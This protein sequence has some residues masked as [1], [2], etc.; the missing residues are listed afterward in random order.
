MKPL[1]L[2]PAWLRQRP[3]LWRVLLLSS[4]LGLAV[5]AVS[6]AS[7]NRLIVAPP[8]IPGATYAGSKSCEDCHEPITRRFATADH[9]RLSAVGKN[10]LDIGCESCH[11]PGSL[12]VESGGELR[13]IIN[14]KKNPEACF[15]CHLDKR[16]QF[17]LPHAHPV[18]AGKVACVD[19][20]HPHE[21]AGWGG[22]AAR[23]A[24]HEGCIQCHPAQ[25]G[26]YAFEHEAM[27]EGCTTCHNPHGTVNAK[28]LTSRNAN[29][30]LKCHVQDA[31][32]S[33]MV[34]GMPH[35]ALLRVGTCWT[36]GCHEAV[37]GSQINSTLRY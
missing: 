28:M 31:N 11:G 15:G 24:H 34:G 1:I 19:C 36:A 29:L 5:A 8:Q 27:R 18:L 10:A 23:Q 20:H 25:R 26:P 6:C 22:G 4:A 17:N 7:T 32:T 35:S 3:A 21:G 30:C 2:L 13:T 37:H 16:G 14:P 9:A 12:H 33:V